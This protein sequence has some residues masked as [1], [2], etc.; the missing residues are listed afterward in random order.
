MS[1]WVELRDERYA[2]LIVEVPNP[3]GD[4]R[5]PARQSYL[6]SRIGPNQPGKRAR[7][8]CALDLHTPIGPL[9]YTR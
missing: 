2:K 1:S 8:S 7:E 9:L 6:R 4:S 3:A 5:P